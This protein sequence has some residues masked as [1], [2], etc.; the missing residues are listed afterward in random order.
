MP[1]RKFSSNGY[2]YGFNGKEKDDEIANVEGAYDDYEARIYDAR[3]G[4]FLSPDFL[5]YN[6]PYNSPYLYARNNPIFNIDVDGMAGENPQIK[7]TGNV[8]IILTTTLETSQINK[9]KALAALDQNWDYVFVNDFVSAEPWINLYS[10]QFGKITN[11]AIRSHGSYIMDKNMDI[12]DHGIDVFYDGKG[13]ITSTAINEYKQGK[14]D[15]DLNK[16][17]K[18]LEDLGKKHLKDDAN[19]I[20]GACGLGQSEELQNDLYKLLDD[21]KSK[22]LTIWANQDVTDPINFSTGEKNATPQDKHFKGWVATDKNGTHD[23]NG[24]SLKFNLI[25]NFSKNLAPFTVSSILKGTKQSDKKRPIS[26]STP[27]FN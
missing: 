22:N 9:I 7:G 26:K 25:F 13:G 17:I 3:L 4:K 1:G 12:V 11:I 5:T 23:Y 18:F 19:I 24:N 15:E 21:K 6:Y 14:G 10:S 20:F 16:Q 27:R 2:R 8:K